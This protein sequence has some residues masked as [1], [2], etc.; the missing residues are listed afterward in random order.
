MALVLSKDPQ[1]MRQSGMRRVFEYEAF[2]YARELVNTWN[3]RR[4]VLFTQYGPYALAALSTVPGLMVAEN[5]KRIH[6]LRPERF[7][8][9]LPVGAISSLIPAATTLV[10]ANIVQRDILLGLTP[11]SVCL[12]IRSICLQ[13][14]TGLL[15]PT[16]LGTLGTYQSL[17]YKDF[18]K[19]ETSFPKLLWTS[20]V[21]SRNILAV[22]G[23][24]Q[25]ITI[26]LL[27]KLW[28]DEW[29]F[30]NE[31]LGRRIQEGEARKTELNS[32]DANNIVN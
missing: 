4:D 22:N 1:E 9:K 23:F 15:V 13:L 10:M 28:Q 29:V 20:L 14:T 25:S 27:V 30:I 32:A 17:F 21:K 6:K 7:L 11:C 8:A 3:P 26:S 24:V 2:S 31:E 12:E 19:S 18:F 5:I 16:M